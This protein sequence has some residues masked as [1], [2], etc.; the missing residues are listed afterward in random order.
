MAVPGPTVTAAEFSMW[1][2]TYALFRTTESTMV[3]RPSSSTCTP[4]FSLPAGTV[5]FS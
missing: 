1:M 3:K 4:L 2:P 5:P